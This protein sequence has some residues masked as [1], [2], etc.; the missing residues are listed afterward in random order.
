VRTLA[1]FGAGR[2]VLSAL[3]AQPRQYQLLIDLFGVLGER[4]ELLG[5]LGMDRH[6]MNLTSLGLLLPGVLL[7]LLAF[8]PMP[9]AQYNM[10]TLAV[11]SLVLMLLLVMEASNS[12]LNPGEV[13][14]LAHRPISGTTYFAAK[15][16]Y[17]IYV[18]LRATAALNGPAAL[19]GLVKAEARWFYP[20]TH[21]AAAATA[22]VFVALIACAVFGL[23]FRIVPVSRVRSVALWLQLVVAMVPLVMNLAFARLRVLVEAI[24]PAGRSIDWSFTPL[25]WFNALAVA[26]QAGPV[27]PL[28]RSAPAG[29]V[30]A[31]LF[32]AY[33]IRSLSAGYM[34]RIVGTLRA[35]GARRSGRARR[36]RVGRAVARLSGGPPGH[37]AFAFI[38]R[39]MR[40][41]WQF[42]RAIVQFGV[43][44]VV[45]VP[46]IVVSGR[47]VSPFAADRLPPIGLLPTVLPLF[48]LAVCG[49]LSYSDHYKGAWIFE[50]MPLTALRQF[51]GGVYWSLWLPFLGA[52]FAAAL[53]F[54]APYWGLRDSALFVAYGVAVASFLFALQLLLVEG[55]PFSSPPRADRAAGLVPFVLFGPVAS[56]IAWVVQGM[57]LFRHRWIT[58]GAAAVFAWAA[59]VTARYT[60]RELRTRVEANAGTLSRT[61]PG[62]DNATQGTSVTR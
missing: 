39:M 3:G 31:T 60:L 62:V 2:R 54:F 20:L 56:G 29:M 57:F 9:L 52:P 50:T 46:A 28:G 25:A 18:V 22:G 27:T 21:L 35:G 41:D 48:T 36:S 53:L 45:F 12:F 47:D 38:S 11:S 33:G 8:G 14:V 30:V 58:A 34:T 44:I 7:A 16:T 32:A 40:R 42:R 23:L 6:A 43:A 10:A 37:A 19:A 26:G 5:N 24:G 13:A 17:L 55:L 61:A 1:S 15:L 49:I 51:I 59:V 4:K